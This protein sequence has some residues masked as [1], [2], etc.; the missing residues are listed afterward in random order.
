MLGNVGFWICYAGI[1]GL[2]VY[3]A[4][5]GNRRR[6]RDP[7]EV[8]VGDDPQCAQCGYDVRGLP[9]HICPECGGDL[10][11]V[12]VTTAQFRQWQRVPSAVRGVIWS[13][14]VLIVGAIAMRAAVVD[15]LPVRQEEVRLTSY[16]STAALQVERVHTDEYD[17]VAS[18]GGYWGAESKTV[19]DELR[20]KPAV[21]PVGA[22]ELRWDF[23]SDEWHLQTPT[24]ERSGNGRPPVEA[25]DAF[26]SAFAGPVPAPMDPG[27]A[28]P[29]PPIV[30]GPAECR[31]FLTLALLEWEPDGR[32]RTVQVGNMSDLLDA[33]QAE[34]RLP[35]PEAWAQATPWTI[36]QI[37]RMVTGMP[38]TLAREWIVIPPLII[39][40]SMWPAVWLVGLV[41]VTRRQG[42]RA[43][44]FRPGEP[45]EQP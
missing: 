39:A 40:G 14:A 19:A 22:V 36:G 10:H 7:I 13:V 34:A 29:R 12:G 26:V 33:V 43:K 5:Y 23:L 15:R 8:S 11:D 44:D 31:I 38:A 6:K 3:L 30:L 24:V 28:V 25:V 41:L 27:T 1:G 18:A 20:V 42:V 17:G 21:N 32:R 35:V 16:G 9:G 2:L 45:V 4:W 37:G